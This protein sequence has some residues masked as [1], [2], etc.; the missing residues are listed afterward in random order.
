MRKIGDDP[1]TAAARPYPLYRWYLRTLSFLRPGYLKS[2]FTMHS[3]DIDLD[4][5]VYYNIYRYLL[6][7]SSVKG[8]PF[9]KG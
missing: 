4:K 2:S 6:F 9:W 3:I 8:R 5:L 7:M 1:A